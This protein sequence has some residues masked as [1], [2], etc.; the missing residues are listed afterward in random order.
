MFKAAYFPDEGGAKLDQKSKSKKVRNSLGFQLA[1][2]EGEA[3]IFN[4]RKNC[5]RPKAPQKASHLV[6]MQRKDLSV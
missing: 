4:Q 3:A 6:H 1:G 2:K 5:I